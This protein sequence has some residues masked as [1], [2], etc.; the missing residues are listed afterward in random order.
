MWVAF[1]EEDHGNQRT[2]SG[3]R[4]IVIHPLT[5]V[6]AFVTA[7]LLQPVSEPSIES[8]RTMARRRWVSGVTLVLGAGTLGWAVRIDP[9]DRPRSSAAAK[10]NGLKAEPGC[11]RLLV[12][13]LKAERW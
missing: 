5:E 12:A 9:G 6:R 4:R 1:A 7:A 3:G 10:T 8:A 11:R 13:R 2:K